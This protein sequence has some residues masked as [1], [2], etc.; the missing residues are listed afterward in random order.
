VKIASLN[1]MADS[2]SIALSQSRRRARTTKITN[3][4]TNK[5]TNEMTNEMTQ[6]LLVLVVL[7]FAAGCRSSGSSSSA[8]GG[9]GGGAAGASGQAGAAGTSGAAGTMG[10][11]GLDGG[12]AGIPGDG[13]TDSGDAADAGGAFVDASATSEAGGAC[14]CEVATNANG[15]FLAMSWDCFCRTGLTDCNIVRGSDCSG[16]I[17]SDDS[18]CSLT[19]I[20]GQTSDGTFE[21]VYDSTGKLVGV[22][23][24]SASGTY[25]CPSDPTLKAASLNAG[26]V[27]GDGCGPL[28]A[29][30]TSCSDSTFPC[31]VPD[32]GS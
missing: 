30:C 16:A 14:S 29:L 13:A 3:E 1:D 31:A 24:T 20:F 8:P 12:D 21:H 18:V 22:G 2:Q 28:E 19:K 23:L 15:S 7:G 9:A 6:S 4:I 26:T 5:V 32:A 25:T 11:A 10:D 27:A 17:R